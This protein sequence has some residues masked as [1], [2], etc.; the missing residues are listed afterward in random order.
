[1]PDYFGI[2]EIHNSIENSNKMSHD[3]VTIIPKV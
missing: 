1:M 3:S 2:L